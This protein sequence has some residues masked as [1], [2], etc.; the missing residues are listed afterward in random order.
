MDTY[1]RLDSGS[2]TTTTG[3]PSVCN[4]GEAMAYVLSIT[5]RCRH[6]RQTPNSDGN[7]EPSASTSTGVGGG[8]INLQSMEQQLQ[9]L[10]LPFLRVAALLRHHLYRQE[11]PH[12][13]AATVEYVRLVYYLELVTDS[14]DWASF[15]AAKGLCFVSGT[16]RT[17]PQYWCGQLIDVRP[18]TDS[19]QQLV[20]SQHVAWQQPRLLKLPTEYERLFTVSL[21]TL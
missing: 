11:L 15:N 21:S 20:I 13:A 6:L 14:M 8:I 2:T 12:V 5:E 17:L 10:C 4:I 7:V 16:E 3:S 1:L 9:K 19:M 18:P